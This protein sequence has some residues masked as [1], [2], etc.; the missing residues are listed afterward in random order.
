M[1]NLQQEIECW[2]FM[3]KIPFNLNFHN[4][5]ILYEVHNPS[6]SDSTNT[7]LDREY[8]LTFLNPKRDSS[9]TLNKYEERQY[10]HIVLF[11]QKLKGMNPLV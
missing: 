9:A 8:Q 3:K 5:S 6:P 10:D 7:F 2:S 11:P 4:S 1:V